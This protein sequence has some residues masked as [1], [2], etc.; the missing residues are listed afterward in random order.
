MNVVTNWTALRAHEKLD[1]T[2]ASTSERVEVAAVVLSS[3][4]TTLT[5]ALDRLPASAWDGLAPGTLIQL[6]R[7]NRTRLRG[8]VVELS[9]QVRPVLVLRSLAAPAAVV[10]QRS[11]GRM[12]VQWRETTVRCGVGEQRRNVRARVV[13]V[14]AGGLCLVMFRAPQPGEPVQ[15]A[16]PLTLRGRLPGWVPV[17]VAW[18]RPLRRAWQV[19]AQF[20]DPPAA[21]QAY[22]ADQ[23]TGDPLTLTGPARPR[24]VSSPRRFST[25][26]G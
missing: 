10:N 6:E 5:L 7:R 18:I 26:Q 9:Y 20:M 8:Q 25:A 16:L 14:S 19:G 1:L 3:T 2:T 22:L 12:P 17:E 24:T 13:D 11:A 23:A 15:L 21:L 4:P